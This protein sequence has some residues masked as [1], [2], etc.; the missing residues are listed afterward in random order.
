VELEL[1]HAEGSVCA[2]KVRIVLSEKQAPWIDRR[3]NLQ[4]AEQTRPEYLK[5]NP[6]GVVPTLVAD[7][8]AVT[9]ST[10]I[11]EFI[12]DILPVPAL[13][14]SDPFGR[15]V[16]RRWAKI[17][18]EGIH[19]ACSAVSHAGLLGHRYRHNLE[20]YKARLDK[21]PDRSRA[22][23]AWRIVA[24][25]FGDPEVRDAVLKHKKL[26]ED[27][28]LALEKSPWLAGD[29]YTLA[30][31]CITPYIFRLEQLGLAG[32]WA[33]R[34][35]V[36]DWLERIKARPSFRE[37]ILGFR[38]EFEDFG[39]PGLLAQDWKQVKAIIDSAGRRPAASRC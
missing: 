35:R 9:E 1:Y 34:R 19:L 13:R 31:A 27:M 22:T 26:L 5:L 6:R 23:R 18:D 20:A 21:H 15:A 37:A 38:A 8:Q 30:D 3:V 32:M 24:D 7:G 28:E 16:M 11:C 4:R 12:E 39:D 17:P 2:Q 10:V 36:A 33:D 14:P 25:G 29:S